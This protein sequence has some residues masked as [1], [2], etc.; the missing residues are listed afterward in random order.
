MSGPRG[1]GAASPL[2]DGEVLVVGGLVG[3]YLTEYVPQD[4]AEI[5]DPDVEEW[6]PTGSMQTAR[7]EPIAAPLPDGRVLVA[8]GWDGEPLSSAE[9]YDP[10]TGAFSPTDSPAVARQGAAAAPL[11]DGRILIAGGLSDGNS[12]ALDSAEI[13]DPASETFESGGMA[14]MVTGRRL[15]AATTLLDGRVLLLAGT[16]VSG[17]QS[18]EFFDPV[19]ET[20]SSGPTMASIRTSTSAATLPDGR[21]LIVGGVEGGESLATTEFFDPAT[22]EFTLEGAPTMLTD[23]YQ[24]GVVPIEGGR[25]LVA[26]GAFNDN[27]HQI[28][29]GSAEIFISDPEEEPEPEG[30]PAAESSAS[31]PAEVQHPAAPVAPL[32]ASPRADAT[33]ARLRC[34]AKDGQRATCVLRF[35]V[36]ADRVTHVSLSRKGRTVAAGKPRLKDGQAILR[37]SRSRPLPRGDYALTV[38]W[39]NGAGS[40]VT[41][42][43][44]RVGSSN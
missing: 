22:S 42:T 3:T 23:R 12:D 38:R 33:D 21:V 32:A 20:F 40:W 39:R 15:L 17:P 25:V 28:A 26:G 30:E 31:K 34:R 2:P 24:A 9:I 6:S 29:R 1:P 41:H 19:T 44:T 4:S 8:G 5:F 11:P 10:E 36:G 13:F 16:P 14:S 35:S 27:Y 43:A 37:F 18:S 7:Y